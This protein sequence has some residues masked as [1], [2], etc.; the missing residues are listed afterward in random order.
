MRKRPDSVLDLLDKEFKWPQEGESLFVE[1]EDWWRNTDIAPN[2]LSRLVFMWDGYKKAADVLVEH[3]VNNN[4]LIDRR[5]MIYPI[6]YCYRHSVELALKWFILRYGRYANVRPKPCHSLKMLWQSYR[7]IAE[8]I[9]P[10]HDHDDLEALNSVERIV[11]EMN[12]V[13][14]TSSAFRYAIDNK[15]KLILLPFEVISLENLAEVM[16]GVHNYFN[17]ADGYLDNLV[18]A[19]P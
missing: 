4:Y 2:V 17:G 18:S 5:E 11:Y 15:G 12:K 10:E 9:D 19:G 16:D 14:P 13:D 6:I 8:T 1:E 3:C 7:K